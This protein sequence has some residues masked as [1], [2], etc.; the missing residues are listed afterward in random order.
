MLKKLISILI[1]SGCGLLYPM[2]GMA[3]SH[4]SGHA[5]MGGG[6]SGTN[7]CQKMSATDMEP[8]ALSELAPNSSFSFAVLGAK[9]AHDIEVTVKKIPVSVEAVAKDNFFEVTAKLPSELKGVF[10]RVNVKIKA[11]VSGCDQESGWLY[12]ISG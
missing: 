5:G 10:A 8:A 7:G 4:H 2:S 9:T 12:K 6:G 3:T 11:Q 1:L